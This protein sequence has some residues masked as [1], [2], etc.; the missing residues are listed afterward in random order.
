MLL[1][2]ESVD[3]GQ[4]Q[5]TAANH[6]LSPFLEGK[7]APRAGLPN[8]RDPIF[9]PILERGLMLVRVLMLQSD[10]IAQ[11]LRLGKPLLADSTVIE[12]A[13]FPN[14]MGQR[15]PGFP[16]NLRK[17]WVTHVAQSR[18]HSTIRI[19][20]GNHR[21]G[22]RVLTRLGWRPMLVQAALVK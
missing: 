20:G 3:T 10:M 17:L 18:R 22:C 14:F 2:Q 4:V 15:L 5:H 13:P 6:M 21:A 1:R 12:S 9:K 11:V 7:S 16:G 19:S 8:A